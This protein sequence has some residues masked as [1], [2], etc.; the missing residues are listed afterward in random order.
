MTWPIENIIRILLIEKNN[1]Q[2]KKALGGDLC[3]SPNNNLKQ[4]LGAELVV[5]HLRLLTYLV[6][7]YLAYQYTWPIDEAKE[8]KLRWVLK[9][10]FRNLL[11]EILLYGGWHY[12]LYESGAVVGRIDQ[13]KFNPENQYDDGGKNIQREVT[14]TTL[15][16]VMSTIYE[17]VILHL[18]S[19]ESN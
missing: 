3:K 15:G 2:S 19:S 13:K 4:G 11:I 7:T 16:F 9:V 18:W 1:K 10:L 12:F 14:F 5:R 8:W 17:C 6:I